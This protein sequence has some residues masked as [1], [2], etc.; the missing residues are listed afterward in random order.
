[1]ELQYESTLGKKRRNVWTLKISQAE[2]T[3]KGK[4]GGHNC[5]SVAK[6]QIFSPESNHDPLLS[7]Y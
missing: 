1:M 3:I 6:T 7:S 4:K 5:T 2:A